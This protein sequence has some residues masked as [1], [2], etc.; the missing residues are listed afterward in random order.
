M[1]NILFSENHYILIPNG[2]KK[3]KDLKVGDKII[4]MMGTPIKIERIIN[5]GEREEAKRMFI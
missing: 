5:C 1:K 3:A 4:D 2:W